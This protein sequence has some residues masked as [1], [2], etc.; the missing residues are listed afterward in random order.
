MEVSNSYDLALA[1]RLDGN[2]KCTYGQSGFIL[3]RFQT[4][5]YKKNFVLN[6]SLGDRVS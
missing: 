2:I 1:Y 6:N 5:A 4:Y 3:N